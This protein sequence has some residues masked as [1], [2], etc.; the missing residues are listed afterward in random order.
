MAQ[1]DTLF[2]YSLPS[3]VSSGGESRVD[4]ATWTPTEP[5]TGLNPYFFS[6]FAERADLV[7]C[8]ILAVA[9]VASSRYFEPMT[10]ARR[11]A[12][13]DPV[14]TSDGERLRFESF[15]M[16]CGVH[17]RL[18]V[19]GEGL[20]GEFI[21]TGTTNVDVNPPLRQALARILRGAPLRLSVGT[22]EFSVETMNG[23]IVE[24]KVTLPDRWVR[25][26]GET[27]VAQSRMSE[28]IKLTGTE[29][30]RLVRSLPRSNREPVWIEQTGPSWR[31]ASE[32]T[33]DAVAIVGGE[34]LQA[35][36]SLLASVER[37]TVY[38]PV[39]S[40]SRAGPSTWEFDFGAVRLSLTMSAA[41]SRGFS[42][43]GGVLASLSN[44]EVD[45]TE[46]AVDATFA[47]QP[48]LTIDQIARQLGAGAD[49]IRQ[50]LDVL[51]ASGRIGFDLNRRSFFRRLLPVGEATLDALNPRLRKAVDLLEADAVSFDQSGLR[52]T[53]ASGDHH[54]IVNLL[55]PVVTGARCTCPWYAKHRGE[56]GPCKHVLA[57]VSH[58]RAR[59]P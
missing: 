1:A 48:L 15:S 47:A 45:G 13:L 39:V 41:P 18:D 6:G 4:L 29:A 32:A 21:S 35:I 22:D 30:A 38:A 3:A 19:E 20:D 7:A 16:C 33:A 57:A 37:L 17:A 28:R 55:G 14:V 25:G 56:R 58:V 49:H 46:G 44:D 43:E 2:R 40:T 50:K 9:Q 51:A 12:I 10:S 26:F 23:R 31:F 52:A 24:R 34:R 27:Q 59:R 53:V 42:G 11:H 36:T 5:G 8:G 54:H